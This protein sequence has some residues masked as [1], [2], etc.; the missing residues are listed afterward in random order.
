MHH[1]PNVKC[2][3]A[4]H[5]RQGVNFC[6]LPH[7]ACKETLV[8]E[9]NKLNKLKNFT[10]TQAVQFDKLRKILFDSG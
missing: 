4:N 2:K 5:I 6:P 8:E 3:Y 1:C 9:Y 10:Y 7:S